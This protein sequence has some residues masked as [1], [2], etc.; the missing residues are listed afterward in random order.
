MI[1]NGGVTEVK[2]LLARL[3]DIP[4]N[5]SDASDEVLVQIYKY[6]I[7][8]GSDSKDG[9]VHW[10]CSRA[11]QLT[12]D[13]STFLLRLFAYNSP[14]V[15]SWKARMKSCLAGCAECVQGLGEVKFSSRLT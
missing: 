8:V 5:T 13:A 1:S 7:G 4:A 9:R 10:F 12:V 14:H 2:A 15:D 6:L 3:R 11:D